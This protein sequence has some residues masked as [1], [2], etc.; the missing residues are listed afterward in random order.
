[1]A[2]K[3][4]GP[5]APGSRVP[6]RPR[7]RT[8]RKAAGTRPTMSRPV[9]RRSSSVVAGFQR[10]CD[11]PTPLGRH[12][13]RKLERMSSGIA[14][15][16]MA[17][18][19]DSVKLRASG[20]TARSSLAADRGSSETPCDCSAQPAMAKRAG[21]RSASS[22][23]QPSASSVFG[24][25]SR[26]TRPMSLPVASRRRRIHGLRANSATTASSSAISEGEASRP[27]GSAPATASQSLGNR[28]R[29]ASRGR[30]SRRSRETAGA[31]RIHSRRSSR[32]CPY[33]V[34]VSSSCW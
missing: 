12:S 11:S 3:T 19:T 34:T 18:P 1:M 27:R 31:L 4:T 6:S 23:V 30:L 25:L 32:N 14:S 21:Q 13:R 16:P 8:A 33:A 26:F 7:I 9:C 29:S 28:M 22:T 17:R 15:P 5:S 24:Y 20:L 2:R 10:K